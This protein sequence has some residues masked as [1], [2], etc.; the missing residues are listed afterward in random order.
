MYKQSFNDQSLREF[1][2]KVHAYGQRVGG[3]NSTKRDAPFVGHKDLK[4]WIREEFKLII[5]FI[6]NIIKSKLMHSEGTPFGQ[7]LNDC[8]TLKNRHKCMD[9]GSEMAC[10][11]LKRNLATCL[12][13]MIIKDSYHETGHDEID[14]IFEEKVGLKNIKTTHATTFNRAVKGIATMFNHDS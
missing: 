1:L 14:K 11:N 12:V 7:E 2:T 5:L 8:V 10:P 4:S 3:D 6:K 9:L 13:L